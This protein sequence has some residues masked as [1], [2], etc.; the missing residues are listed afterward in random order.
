MKKILVAALL[1][2]ATF[3]LSAQ[4]QP[5]SGFQPP[6]QENGP[7]KKRM[8]KRFDKDGDGVLSDQERAEMQKE[9]GDRMPG[10]Q[11]HSGQGFGIREKVGG[12]IKE[13]FAEVVK[14][15]QQADP[16]RYQKLLK[17]FDRNSDNVLD[18]HEFM[19]MR[20][21]QNIRKM[22]MDRFDQNKDGSLDENER[23]QFEAEHQKNMEFFQQVEP[24]RFQLALGQ[25]DANK[26][27][28][29]QFE[30]WSEAVRKGTLPP[31]GPPQGMS[32]QMM[33]GQPPM[34]GQPPM[35]FQ[36]Q[37]GPGMP[38]Q[39]GNRPGHPGNMGNQNPQQPP[40]P[41]VT[42]DDGGLLEGITLG[43]TEP[44]KSADEDEVD[45]DLG[46][47]FLDF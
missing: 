10:N 19:T 21:E 33:G 26:D 47:D 37:P 3:S 40:Q 14:K 28:K 22:I 38:N 20:S 17:K 32:G 8:L 45:F 36:G 9:I 4:E 6:G 11:R 25:H 39:G 24:Q 44:A 15:I 29:L 2:G 42:G 30:E 34:P 41:P 1:V 12:K 23:A 43:G 16:E 7:M 35:S 13:K 27:G 46:E 31:P 5:G 18:E